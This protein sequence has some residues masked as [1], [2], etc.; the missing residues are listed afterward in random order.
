MAQVR[1]TKD[2]IPDM[3]KISNH[4]LPWYYNIFSFPENQMQGKP[5]SNPK[6]QLQTN[7]RNAE[8]CLGWRSVSAY[9]L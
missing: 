8:N 3:A 6:L 7:K 9:P 1:V 4:C 2:D 5:S